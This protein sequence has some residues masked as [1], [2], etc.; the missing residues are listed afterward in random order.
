[1]NQRTAILALQ[2][3]LQLPVA[4]LLPGLQDIQ[5]EEPHITARR[6]TIVKDFVAFPNLLP[7]QDF[8]LNLERKTHSHACCVA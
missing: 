4:R 1:M 5:L 3:Y 2:V 8:E 7:P 6:D